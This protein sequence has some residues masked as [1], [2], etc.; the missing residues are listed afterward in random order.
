MTET[1]Y[2]VSECWFIILPQDTC[3]DLD[4]DKILTITDIPSASALFG[5]RRGEVWEQNMSEG[6]FCFYLRYL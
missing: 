3:R 5:V 4:R 2:R 6:F 1:S